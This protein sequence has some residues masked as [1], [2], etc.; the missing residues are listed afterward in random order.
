MASDDPISLQFDPPITFGFLRTHAKIT[1]RDID[2]GL[3]HGLIDASVP[4]EMAAATLLEEPSHPPAVADLAV[5]TTRDRFDVMD[6]VKRLADEQATP[7]P[8]EER[9]KWLFLTL[10]WLYEN[11]ALIA[12]PLEALNAVYAEFGYPEE[13]KDF[14]PYMPMSGPDLGSK[15]ANEARLYERWHDYLQR[16]RSREADS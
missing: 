3:K 15:S 9:R 16:R 5:L 7:L 10:A 11:R 13:I 8:D 6:N 14:I 12:Q 1:W 4:I 2:Y